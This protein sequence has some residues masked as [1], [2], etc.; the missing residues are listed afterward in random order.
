VGVRF[1]ISFP[2]GDQFYVRAESKEVSLYNLKTGKFAGQKKNW[3][4]QKKAS[5][6]ELIQTA[7]LAFIVD[8]AG[9]VHHSDDPPAW[10]GFEFRDMHSLK[11]ELMKKFQFSAAH[12]GHTPPGEIF[13]SD[14]ILRPLNFIRFFSIFNKILLFSA[15]NLNRLMKQYFN[16]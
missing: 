16:I 4:F 2:G 10:Y 12:S 6:G 11:E 14:C 5:F 3:L 15:C 1:Y 7:D 13:R 9:P 8:K